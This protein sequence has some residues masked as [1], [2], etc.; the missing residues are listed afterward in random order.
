MTP[1]IQE[2]VDGCRAAADLRVDE[3]VGRRAPAAIDSAL[4]ARTRGEWASGE[5]ELVCLTPLLL[6]SLLE[7]AAG[8]PV[9]VGPVCFNGA[10]AC[11]HAAYE[12][13]PRDDRG[14]VYA[15]RCP[16]CYEVRRDG[17]IDSETFDRL[18]EA[19]G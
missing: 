9:R 15:R 16:D 18:V 14:V 3:E 2:I 13:L 7:A 4:E 12:A 17:G 1:K 8:V 11:D 5:R 10:P 6:A 19:D